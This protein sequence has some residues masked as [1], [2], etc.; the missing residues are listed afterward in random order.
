MK[1]I[2]RS[3]YKALVWGAY[4]AG[5]TFVTGVIIIAVWGVQT[6]LA[7]AG[8]PKLFDWIPLRYIFDVVD[9]AIVVAFIVFGTSEAIVVFRENVD[10]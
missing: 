8:D 10:D 4:V 5:H 6:L 7:W 9:L 2:Q 3:A 1:R